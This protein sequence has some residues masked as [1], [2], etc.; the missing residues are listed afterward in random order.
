MERDTERYAALDLG[1]NSFHLLLAEFRD[2]RMVRLHTDRAM[3]RLAEGLDEKRNLDPAVAERALA[4]MRRFQPVLAELP[5]DH[6]RVVGTNTL[7]A[8]RADGFLETA[9]SIL[10]API[11]IISGIEEARLIYTGVLAAADGP[12]RLRCTVDIGGGSTELVRGR[13]V[14]QQLQS[15]YMG[16]VSYHRR[17]FADGVIAG[18]NGGKKKS[19]NNFNRACRA[20]RAELQGLQHLADS[21]E[22]VGASGTVKSVARVL[23]GGDLEPIHRTDIDELAERVAA[24]ATI[25]DLDLPNLDEARRP[26]FAAGL[27]ILH[28]IFS[29][30]R[31]EEMQVSPYAIRE[32]IVHDLAGRLHGGDRRADTVANMMQRGQID[33]DQARRVGDTAQD[34]LLQLCPDCSSEQLQRLRWAARLHE[35]GL[36]LSH[37]SFRKLGAYMIEQADMAGFARAEQEHLAHL[38]R[39]QRGRL[40][41]PR[42]HYGFHPNPALTLCLRLACIV[43]RDHT[44]RS[45]RGLQL[46]GDKNHYRLRAEQA[47]LDQHP[48]IEDLLYQEVE[49]WRNEP[50]PLELEAV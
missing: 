24:T 1:S 32:G 26:I 8:A 2:Q 19:G 50:V 21:A 37:S 28:G 42:E 6:I 36:A 41:P 43:H 46:G 13:E 31:I 12:P 9:E 23:N 48:A 17:F 30:L 10:G 45:T 40:K 22:V 4:A 38:V 35:F 44:D 5:T 49:R 11:E 18:K 16:C 25:D 7:R 20:A 34:L 14:P 15:L 27:A 33:M 3:V 29:E 39:N 47:W